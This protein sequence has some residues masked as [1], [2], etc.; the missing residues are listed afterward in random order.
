MFINFP[1]KWF[2]QCILFPCMLVV[3]PLAESVLIHTNL[4][5]SLPLCQKNESKSKCVFYCIHC[6]FERLSNHHI[7]IWFINSPA[8]PRQMVD[9]PYLWL[10]ANMCLYICLYVY[11]ICRFKHH[12]NWFPRVS[13]IVIKLWCSLI[14]RCGWFLKW[15]TQKSPVSILSHGHPWLGWCTGVPPWLRTTM[16]FSLFSI[17]TTDFPPNTSQ[18]SQVFVQQ[19]PKFSAVFPCFFSVLSPLC[20]PLSERGGRA[21]R[22]IPAPLLAQQLRGHLVERQRL[23]DHGGTFAYLAYLTLFSKV[24][25]GKCETSWLLWRLNCDLDD[26][27]MGQNPGT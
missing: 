18:F 24:R 5:F 13:W 10:G 6:L 11:K 3:Y 19:K 22:R 17:V 23:V 20:G 25:T 9:I 8:N 27:G 26:L 1:G 21:L 2:R 14:F 12:I 7:P 16:T 15:E 4:M